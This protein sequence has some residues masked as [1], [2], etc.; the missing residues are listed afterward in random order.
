MEEVRVRELMLPGVGYRYELPVDRDRSLVLVVQHGGGREIG[1]A[2]PGHDGLAAAVKLSQDQAAA[3]AA[4]LTGARFALEPDSGPA[5]G[6][7]VAVETA[8]LGERSPAVG[9][10]VGDVSRLAGGD[11]VI[12]AVIRDDTPQ[13]VEDSDVQPCRAGDRLVVA[14]RQDRLAEVVR[15]LTG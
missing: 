15:E 12:L 8:T 4:L 11:A 6:S 9:H 13:L 10:L 2:L 3:V 7:V 14:A 5:P 1:I